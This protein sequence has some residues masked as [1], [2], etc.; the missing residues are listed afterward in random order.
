MNLHLLAFII[1]I[2]PVALSPGA[3][4]T[5]AM[6]NTLVAGTRGLASIILGTALG[7]YTHALLI[8]LG[9]SALLVRSPIIFNLL[10]VAGAAYLLWL[11]VQ[12][13]RRVRHISQPVASYRS[14]RMGIK[15][16]WLANVLNPK[17][18]MLYLTVVSQFA[19]RDHALLHYLLLASIHVAIMALW[20][21]IICFTLLTSARVIN[22]RKLSIAIN[23]GGGLILVFFA[24]S[25]LVQLFM[26]LKGFSS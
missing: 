17:A 1:A 23:I 25:N 15:D 16:A 5:L 13:L 24:I 14:A 20:L 21:V 8:G 22:I 6:N 7:I 3:S 26:T 2:L 18:V 9:I 11:G 10:S 12:L 19:G 4:F